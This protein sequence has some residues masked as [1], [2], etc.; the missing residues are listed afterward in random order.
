M[1]ELSAKWLHWYIANT[2]RKSEISSFIDKFKLMNPEAITSL[3]EYR[4]FITEYLK[5]KWRKSTACKKTYERLEELWKILSIKNWALTDPISHFFYQYYIEELSLNDIFARLEKISPG[6]Y[7]HPEGLWKLFTKTFKWDLRDNTEQTSMRVKKQKVE[8]RKRQHKMDAA[9]QRKKDEAEA[10]FKLWFIMNSLDENKES[11]QK[12]HYDS[13]ANKTERLKYLLRIFHWVNENWINSFSNY[14]L[15]ATVVRRELN[16]LLNEA[17]E[18]L[19]I[20]TIV[21]FG[22]EIWKILQKK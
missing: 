21:M 10:K 7:A 12:D 2:N 19:W 3:P 17:C 14:W 18:K 22:W 4:K 11:F 20:K 1:N 13:L 9:N 6:F 16:K 15:W 8:E 5:Q